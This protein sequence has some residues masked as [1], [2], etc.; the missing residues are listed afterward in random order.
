MGGIV[1]TGTPADAVKASFGAATRARALA[2]FGGNPAYHAAGYGS[3]ELSGFHPS[4]RSPDSEVLPGRDKIVARSRDLDRN[5]GWAQGGFERRGDAV[6]GPNL[7][8]RCRPDFEAMGMGPD[9]AEWADTWA[10]QVE[11]LWRVT[12]NDPRFLFDVERH[13]HFGGQMRLAYQHYA[14][15]GEAAAAI[16]MIEDRGAVM[17]TALLI[18]DPDRLANPRFKSDDKQYRGGVELDRYGA[19]VAYH[20]RKSHVNDVG[21]T[22]DAYETVRIP[23]EGPTGRPLFIHAINK[24]RAHQHRSVGRLASVMGSMR[25]LDRYDQTELQAAIAN[26]VFGLYVTS[27]SPTDSVRD[28]MAPVDDTGT[29]SE[30]SAYM[31]DRI[32]YHEEADLTLNGVRLAHL[33]DREKIE[34][35]SGSRSGTNFEAFEGAILRRIASAFGLSYE[36]LSNDWSGINYSS[37][38]TLLNEIWRGLLADRHLFTQSFCTP[39]FAAWLEEAVA[40]D[41]IQVPGGKAMF[42][43]HRAALT[44]CDWIGPGRGYIDPKKEAEAAKLRIE[45]GLSSQTDEC[46]EQGRDADQVR[47][48]RKRDQEADEAYGLAPTAP[49][50]DRQPDEESQ[51]AADARETRGEDA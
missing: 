7:R 33:W 35:V 24:K 29:A 5:N 9:G 2:V 21:S 27:N 39:I 13:Q 26:A 47:W 51:D 30:S 12:T 45:L 48:R 22:F 49:A 3:Q 6:V 36:Q 16:Y 37:A 42:Y 14:L 28:A 34:T 17:S 10:R 8:L 32:A 20:V 25:M 41:M 11:A 1:S 43:V 19:A 31:A 23:R 44:Q 4:L 40:R 15:D 18:V 50:A 38:R 46:E